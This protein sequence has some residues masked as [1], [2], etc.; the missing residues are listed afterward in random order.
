MI[1]ITWID[2]DNLLFRAY[3]RGSRLLVVW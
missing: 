1:L 3:H 2:T